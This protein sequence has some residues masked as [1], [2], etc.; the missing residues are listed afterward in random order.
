MALDKRVLA[1]IGAVGA[2]LV[3]GFAFIVWDQFLKPP[4]II[5]TWRGSLTDYE[6][7]HM[8]THTNYDLVLDEKHRASMTLQDKFTSVG[9]Y[10]LKGSRLKLSLKGRD[11]EGKLEDTPTETEYKIS[12]GSATLELVDPATNKLVVQLIRFREPP[13]IGG[14]SEKSAK[15]TTSA[16]LAADLKRPT[17]PRI[18]S[19]FPRSFLPRTVRS[20]WR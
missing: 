18:K 5:G 9:T 16:N 10:S 17:R 7:G 2:I 6:I 14:K 15:Q 8:I 19:W 12:L 11:E 1:V 20:R 3:A 4:S 13:A